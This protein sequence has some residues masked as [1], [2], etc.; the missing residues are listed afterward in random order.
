[1]QTPDQLNYGQCM[2]ILKEYRSWNHGQR[3]VSL[4]FNGIRTQEDD[5]YDIRR[6]LILI[7]TNRLKQMGEPKCKH[8]TK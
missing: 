8:L 5:I 2:A 4:S 3:S 1:M 6:K 7:A